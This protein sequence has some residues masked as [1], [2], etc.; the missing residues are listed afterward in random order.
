MSTNL[1][2]IALLSFLISGA[3]L[4]TAQ[5]IVLSDDFQS[6]K[7]G[8]YENENVQ[9]HNGRYE[10]TN[11]DRAEY[12]WMNDT[13]ED[14]SVEADTA[15]L[16]DQETQGYGLVFRLVDAQ[17]FYFIWLTGAG[18]YTVGKVVDDHAIPIK[19]WTPSE[20]INKRGNNNLR[21]ELCGP[22]MNIFIN[23]EKVS[24][25]QD[26]TFTRGGY[27]FYTHAGV[28]V[29]YDNFNVVSGSPF[30]IHMPSNGSM[31][32]FRDMT[33]KTFTLTLTGNRDGKIWGTDIYTDDSDISTA[34]VHTNALVD[35][36]TGTILITMLAGQESYSSSE[37]NGV[38]S[39][40]FGSW[41]GSYRIERLK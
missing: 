15:W 27:G 9:I 5:E 7:N 8:W 20:V 37:R 16:G 19:G 24:V 1:F 12:T 17:N 14:G 18:N 38:R 2:K 40:D 21:V 22:L 41:H 33:G 31:D 35:G 6:N 11:K 30:E 4:I 32:R 10:F 39:N 13:F 3:F 34:A 36:E 26:D 28:H 29:G 23:E 25:L